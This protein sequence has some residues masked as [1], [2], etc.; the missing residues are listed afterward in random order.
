VREFVTTLLDTAGLLLIAAGVTV[1]A[2]PLAGSG[3]GL[4]LGGVIVLFGSWFATA[5]LS[6]IARK[7]RRSKRA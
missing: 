2:W 5:D 4:V 3:A 1:I 6:G 7:L